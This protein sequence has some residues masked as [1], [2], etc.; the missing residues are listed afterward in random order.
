MR[1][2]AKLSLLTSALLLS[3]CAPFSIGP[4]TKENTTFIR[5]NDE[6]GNPVKVGHIKHNVKATIQY[7]RKDDTTGEATLDIG[8]WD[9]VPPKENK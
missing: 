4:T 6:Q 8:G 9:V 1:S 3:G 7:V 2:L 5:T